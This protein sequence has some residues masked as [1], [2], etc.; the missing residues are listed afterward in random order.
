MSELRFEPGA[1]TR[2]PL[3]PPADD[4]AISISPG[5]VSIH[6]PGYEDTREI[7]RFVAYNKSKGG[8]RWVDYEFVHDMCMAI[9]GHRESGFFTLGRAPNTPKIDREQGALVEGVKTTSM[10]VLM[11]RMSRKS[12][13]W[14]G[15]F[16]IMSFHLNM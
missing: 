8:R 2:S 6:H 9:T 15:A 14:S 4:L 12:T 1:R 5:Y 16:E 7:F 13:R 11:S 10:L 3:R